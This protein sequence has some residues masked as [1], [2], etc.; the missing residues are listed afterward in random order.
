MKARQQRGHKAQ[1]DPEAASDQQCSEPA[2]AIGHLIPDP[3]AHQRRQLEGDQE[4]CAPAV[5]EVHRIPQID[6]G[7]GL[8]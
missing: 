3:Q 2:T 5:G 7:H 4:T 8:H 6:D 1:G